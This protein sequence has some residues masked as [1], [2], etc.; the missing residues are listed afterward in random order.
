MQSKL[1]KAQIIKTSY[2]DPEKLR[3]TSLFKNKKKPDQKIKNKKT[4][5]LAFCFTWVVLK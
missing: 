3:I 1:Q 2:G 4:N 5:K